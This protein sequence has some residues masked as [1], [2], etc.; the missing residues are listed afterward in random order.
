MN[1]GALELYNQ[2]IFHWNDPET[3]EWV[4]RGSTS[5]HPILH[6]TG[7]VIGIV[8]VSALSYGLAS[9]LHAILSLGFR[10]VLYLI[11][12]L[13]PIAVGR[14]TRIFEFSCTLLLTLGP[15]LLLIYLLWLTWRGNHRQKLQAES[16][17]DGFLTMSLGMI[18]WAMKNLASSGFS[19]N[20]G[21]LR[22]WLL[23]WAEHLVRAI[24]LDIP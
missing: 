14:P 20:V 23:F 7:P 24:T 10:A 13:R 21:S 1:R 18:A 12:Y 2:N 19:G 16:F 3:Y 5:K 6:A 17:L 9:F 22:E 11:G 8:F 15:F 4:I